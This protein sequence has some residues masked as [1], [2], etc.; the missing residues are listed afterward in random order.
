MVGTNGAEAQAVCEGEDKG[1]KRRVLWAN[2]NGVQVVRG[3]QNQA[4][5]LMKS[6]LVMDSNGFYDACTRQG[7]A[8]LGMKSTKDG[9]EALV[10]HDATPADSNR[11]PTWCPRD[12][13]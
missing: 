9:V 11:T 12:L 3:E 6:L 4:G 2:L 5:A 1:W 13:N 10:V 7:S 8:Q